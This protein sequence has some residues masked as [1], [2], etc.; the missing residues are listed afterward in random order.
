MQSWLAH[1]KI[2][3]SYKTVGSMLR[4]YRKLF[5]KKFRMKKDLKINK[6]GG[7]NILQNDRFAKYRWGTV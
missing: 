4:L 5:G 1:A 7:D 2:A 3:D 6:G